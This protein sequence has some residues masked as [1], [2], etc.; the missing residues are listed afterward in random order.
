MVVYIAIHIEH[1]GCLFDDDYI[2]LLRMV[3]DKPENLLEVLP[4]LR[5][6][7]GLY[8]AV[9]LAMYFGRK[10]EMP[11]EV[12]AEDAV[13][14]E[15]Y[16]EIILRNF[17]E[18]LVEQGCTAH[19]DAIAKIREGR[20]AGTVTG[21]IEIGRMN[22]KEGRRFQFLTSLAYLN[23]QLSDVLLA[24]VQ[25]SAV[26]NAEVMLDSMSNMNL[27]GGS[28]TDVTFWG[29]DYDELFHIDPASYIRWAAWQRYDQIL[30]R[31]LEKNQESYLKV[32]E[33][34]ECRRLVNIYMHAW[35]YEDNSV[36]VL[37]SM[38]CILNALK[39]VMQKANPSL[40]EQVVKNAKP[41]YE[42]V[43]AKLVADTPHAKLAKEYLRGNCRFS[44]LVPYDKEFG[45]GFAGIYCNLKPVIQNFRKHC[46][47]PDFINRCCAFLVLRKYQ[48]IEYVMKDAAVSRKDSLDSFFA[49]LDS[50]G[51]E[52]AYQLQA[53]SL[54]YKEV[55]KSASNFDAVI[56]NYVRSVEK[57]FTQFLNEN[58]EGT[59]K[60]FSEAA[61][62][63]RYLGL[64]IL[65]KE[66][67]KYKQE[68][69]S[70][71][72]DSSSLVSYELRQI[73][74]GQ[75]DWEEDVKALLNGKKASQRELAIR[76][77]LQ[78]QEEGKDYRALLSQVLAAEKSAKLVTFLHRELRMEE[79]L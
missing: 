74:C 14:M 62:E 20:Q 42:P 16:E 65:G 55:P 73:L 11:G 21:R 19:K 23:Y 31:Q 49:G 12:S 79:G 37:D 48:H 30:V 75:K 41:D 58:A 10:Y 64:H 67:Q 51:V 1:P 29:M 26:V 70:Y 9:A 15:E 68:I 17:E 3:Q 34:E 7:G 40:Y 78:W 4:S 32:M 43:I 71:A 33:R 53:F 27:G 22:T 5:K 18:W 38:E 72:K 28:R 50:E 76:V 77:L 39:D 56:E 25:T 46:D 54:L 13:L 59:I 24:V 35:G 45:D 57:I 44:E 69:L 36:Q 52:I 60:A 8:A 2:C 63:G 61:P 66:P 47:D 6:E